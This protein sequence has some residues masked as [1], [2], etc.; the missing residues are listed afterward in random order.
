MRS[1]R[2]QNNQTSKRLKTRQ[3]KILDGPLLKEWKPQCHKGDHWEP[4][5]STYG[6][7]K[8]KC[9]MR[10]SR[11]PKLKIGGPL[12]HGRQITGLSYHQKGVLL[13]IL[14]DKSVIKNKLKLDQLQRL[15][16]GTIIR[17]TWFYEEMA[18]Y[19]REQKGHILIMRPLPLYLIPLLLR[20]IVYTENSFN[21]PSNFRACKS[22]L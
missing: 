5:E 10:T 12:S 14:K 8:R 9:R 22:F 21:K 16:L 17:T 7:R 6:L 13:D 1:G 18:P 2:V 11:G 15:L 4:Y 19:I 3:S 20:Q